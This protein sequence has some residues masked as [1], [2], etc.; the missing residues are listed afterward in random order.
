MALNVGG[1]IGTARKPGSGQHAKEFVFQSAAIQ[2]S[3][4]LT[5]QICDF[6]SIDLPQIDMVAANM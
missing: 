1:T 5:D 2:F 4:F 3:D 6:I